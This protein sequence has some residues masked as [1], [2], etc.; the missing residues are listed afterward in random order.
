MSQQERVP[1]H[2]LDDRFSGIHLAP[3]GGDKPSPAAYDSSQPHRHDFYYCVLL[4]KGRLEMEVDFQPVHLPEPSLYLSYPGQIHQI[5]A[6]HLEQGWY[7]TF[8][9]A[10]IEQ[11]LRDVLDQCLSEVM[12]VPLL[13][14]QAA[15]FSRLLQHLQLVQN[16]PPQLFRQP[17]LQHLTTAFVY[18]L[19]AAYLAVEQFS[20]SRHSSRSIEIT[21][22]FKQ[23]L[24]QQPK[25]L[26]RPAEFAAKL[27]ITVSH[28]NDTVRR[29]TG[30]PVTYHVQQQVMQEAQRLLAHSELPVNE[31]AYALGFDDA[32]YFIRLFRKVIGVSPGTFRKKGEPAI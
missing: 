16:E 6:A 1:I 24:R 7:L 10:V 3:F 9:A 18:E 23:L 12:L 14:A 32:K 21:K 29:V 17:V 27:H 31:I 4:E 15:R 20:L 8:E 22:S 13:P 11:L 28:L 30:F 19:A 2:R 25:Q 5:K 26:N